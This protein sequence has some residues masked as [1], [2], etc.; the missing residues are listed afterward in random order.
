MKVLGLLRPVHCTDLQPVPDRSSL[1]SRHNPLSSHP[2]ATSKHTL[3][4]HIDEVTE[5]LD[6]GS[7]EAASRIQWLPDTDSATW[8]SP[9]APP[10]ISRSNPN[11]SLNQQQQKAIEP[12]AAPAASSPGRQQEGGAGVE[13]AVAG[14]AEASEG[15][16]APPGGWIVG[17]RK[18]RH[19]RG[20]TQ[21]ET[22]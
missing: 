11:A 14:T 1:Y 3:W 22:G 20:E 17:L 19:G 18:K 12:G 16:A 10:V 7:E 5:E 9:P 15:L 13:S 6:L 2:A 21:S 4:Y 8:P